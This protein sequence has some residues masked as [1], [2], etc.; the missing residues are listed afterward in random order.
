MFSLPQ[1]ATAQSSYQE[2]ANGY[3]FA[4]HA[5][6]LAYMYWFGCGIYYWCRGSHATWSSSRV[7]DASA[8]SLQHGAEGRRLRPLTCCCQ[9]IANVHHLQKNV[10]TC[11]CNGHT[12]GELWLASLSGL[13]CLQQVSMQVEIIKKKHK[14]SSSLF[15]RNDTRQSRRQLQLKKYPTQCEH[16]YSAEYG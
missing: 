9:T 3:I 2:A 13:C 14:D 1:S 16:S 7:C 12:C 6:V 8:V 10:A 5:Y 15:C 11:W 4:V